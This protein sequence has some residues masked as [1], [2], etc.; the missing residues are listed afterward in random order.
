MVLMPVKSILK[1]IL[2][3]VLVGFLS[4]CN[5]QISLGGFQPTRLIVQQAITMQL[6]ITKAELDEHLKQ[7]NLDRKKL[8]NYEINR[9]VILNEEPVVIQDLIA[10]HIRGTYN[11]TFKLPDGRI[12][13][14]GN[15]FDIYLQLQKEAKSWRLAIQKSS[16]KN[17]QPIWGTYLIKPKGYV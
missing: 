2:S 4:A 9:V 14:R 13:D 8:P 7:H 5:I 10:Y 16:G 15:L 12:T 6:N 1:I 11:L 3:M 17:D